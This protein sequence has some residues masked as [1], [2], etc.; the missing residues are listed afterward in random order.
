MEQDL[1]YRK[2]SPLELQCVFCGAGIHKFNRC[3]YATVHSDVSH[4]F[5]VATGIDPKRL[6]GL[7]V[8][9]QRFF[10]T[11]FIQFL[12]FLNLLGKK[13]SMW[14]FYYSLSLTLVLNP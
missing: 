9:T 7:K 2:L 6:Q 12:F 11:L 8:L 3:K 13:N 1:N 10:K 14:F 5:T 4:S